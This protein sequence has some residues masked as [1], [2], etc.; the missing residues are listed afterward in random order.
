MALGLSNALPAQ[1]TNLSRYEKR[2]AMFHPVAAW[3]VKKKLPLAFSIYHQVKTDGKLDLFESGGKLDAFRHVFTMA[4]LS[5]SIP[6][7]KLRKLGIAHEKG[8]YLDFKHRQTEHTELPD[9]LG[10]DMDLRNNE[11]GFATGKASG[12]SSAEE[13]SEQVVQLIRQGGAWYLKRNSQ[14]H[15]TDCEG[16]ELDLTA[17]T[18][19]WYIPKCLV[20]TSE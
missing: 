12:T 8:N 13:L 4:Y 15:Y 20:K 11:V 14:G 7:R 16:R 19:Q 9:S 1:T 3:R 10:C 6:V 17:Y 5:Q 18:G 2:W